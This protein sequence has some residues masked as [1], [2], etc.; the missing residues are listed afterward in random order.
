MSKEAVDAY[1]RFFETFN[2]RDAY[3]FSSAMSYPHVRV[4]WA[5]KPVVLADAEA[6][7]LSVS[8]DAFIASGWDHTEGHEPTVVGTS[9]TKVHL[10]GGWTR[11]T[12]QGDPILSNRVCYIATAVEGNWG[13]QCRFGSDPGKQ[14]VEQST[15]ELAIGN[16]CVEGFVR[17]LASGD[18][19]VAGSYMADEFFFIDIGKVTRHDVARGLPT[20]DLSA[21]LEVVQSG[22]SSMTV[23]AI[24]KDGMAMFYATRNEN[25]WQMKAGSWL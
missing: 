9:A 13:I 23:N 10:A 11:M 5:R 22:P 2:T 3:S 18:L 24:G 17:A 19:D 15:A 1:W 12:A 21:S 7:A 25:Q 4:S 14:G 16:Q 20:V 8:W 6:H